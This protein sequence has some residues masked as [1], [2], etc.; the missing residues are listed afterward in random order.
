MSLLKN[1]TT[2]AECLADELINVAKDF[3]NRSNDAVAAKKIVNIGGR[4]DHLTKPDTSAASSTASKSG[5]HVLRSCF[6]PSGNVLVLFEEKLH[7]QDVNYQ[8]FVLIFETPTETCQSYTVRDCHDPKSTSII[9]KG[10]DTKIDQSGTYWC[11]FYLQAY[12]HSDFHISTEGKIRAPHVCVL[13][14]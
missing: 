5:Y 8:L 1:V 7:S 6:K 11:S 12:E 4:A 2:I 3:S 13:L 10:D 9:E 14:M